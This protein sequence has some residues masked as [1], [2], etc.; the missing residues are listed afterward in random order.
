[1]Q[2]SAKVR[3]AL[4][5]SHGE[6]HSFRAA[7]AEATAIFLARGGPFKGR[8]VPAFAKP[9]RTYCAYLAQRG[10]GADPL[11]ERPEPAPGIPTRRR[12]HRRP[13][14]PC[15]QASAGRNNRTSPAA[16]VT[17]G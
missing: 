8:P 2:E 17:G 5:A 11:P 14:K 3:A 12:F 16:S 13:G 15:R 10:W 9:G 6:A 7:G 4:A 1:M